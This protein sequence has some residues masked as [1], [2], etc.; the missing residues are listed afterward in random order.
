M[1]APVIDSK[2]MELQRAYLLEQ[3][4]IR[5]GDAAT[6]E[7]V[8]QVADEIF[9]VYQ[10]SLGGPLFQARKVVYGEFPFLEDYY[11]NNKEMEKDL[12]ILFAELNTIAMY[13]V[14]YF[15]Y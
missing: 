4:R 14:D 1:D 3:A 10:N 5:L 13:L 9:Y 8:S 11:D 15:N 6:Q 7:E 12:F 2:I